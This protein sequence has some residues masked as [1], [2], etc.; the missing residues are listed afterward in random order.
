MDAPY[1][2]PS[3]AGYATGDALARVEDYLAACGRLPIA[4]RT[5]AAYLRGKGYI[6]PVRRSDVRDFLACDAERRGEGSCSHC[7]EGHHHWR[8]ASYLRAVGLDVPEGVQ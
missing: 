1:A 8:P 5:N 4:C 3:Y 7:R 2:I 6:S